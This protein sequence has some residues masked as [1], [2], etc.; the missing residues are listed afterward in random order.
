[1]KYLKAYTNSTETFYYSSG[2]ITGNVKIYNSNYTLYK[3]FD[4]LIP[5]GYD[6]AILKNDFTLSKNIFNTNDKLEIVVVLSRYNS[7]TFQNEKMIRIYDEDGVIIKEF[8]NNYRFEELYDFDI[9][10][11]NST[12]SNKLLLFNLATNSTEIWNLG[13][14]SLAAREI[15]KKNKL[16]AFPIPTNKTLTIINP[17]NGANTIEV[18]DT[19]GKLVINK[20][21]GISEDKISID[22][23]SLPKG[24]YIYKVGNLSSKFMKN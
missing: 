13:T 2:D 4:P 21:F 15:Q 16:S 3:Q 1:M 6:A 17:E 19:S 14:T 18:F 20:S 5:T 12:N 11:D 9:Y 10:H 8:G 24:S 22:V 23:E 7:T